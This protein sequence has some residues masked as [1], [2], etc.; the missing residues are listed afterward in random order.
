MWQFA[1]TSKVCHKQLIVFITL[2]QESFTFLCYQCNL[3]LI[4][5]TSGIESATLPQTV[6]VNS[7]SSFLVLA[8]LMH[9]FFF[10]IKIKIIWPMEKIILEIFLDSC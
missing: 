7:L 1:F 2:V 3:T 9:L 6:V 8:T 10:Q 5:S 4:T